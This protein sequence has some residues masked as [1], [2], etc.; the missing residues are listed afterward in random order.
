M[1]LSHEIS[2]QFSQFGFVSSLICNSVFLYL[3][4][5][6]IKKITGT[7]KLMVL[8][9]A[10]VGIVF[11]AW[12]LIA[13]PF[14]HSFNAGFV[15]F[16]L[17]SLIQEYPYFFQFAILLYASFYIVILAIIAVQFAFRYSTLYKP[18]IAKN[19]GGYGVIV[20]MLYCIFCGLIYGAAL[21]HFGH[22]DDYSDDYMSEPVQKMY[23]YSI[24][25]LP[26]FP[27]IPYAADG[28][29]RW[30]NI[31]FLIIGVFI[32]NIQYVIILYFGVRMRTIL[33]NELQQQS[34]VNQKLQK[35]FFKA[36]VVQTV[37]PTL[38]FVLPI[39]PILIAPLFEP[40]ITIKMNLPSGWVYVIVSMF[41]PVDTIA[42]MIIVKEYRTALKDLFNVIFWNKFN[43]VSD[44]ST[45]TSRTT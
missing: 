41:P 3:T 12:D 37:V 27:I 2:Y 4:A 17:N 24:T 34:I 16:S 31:Y 39:A 11:S 33:K 30:N 22:P 45:R 15:Y 5:F 26:R 29:V 25:S 32:I 19:F 1:H 23:N 10:S 18:N 42:F 20:W 35:Q 36:L 9:F 43:A 28:S 44:V 6:R 21:G 13:R 7:Y 38:F 40:L 14:A 8:V